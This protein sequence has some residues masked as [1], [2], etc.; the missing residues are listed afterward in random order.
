MLENDRINNL[1]KKAK[2]A[3]QIQMVLSD[4]DKKRILKNRAKTAA[5]E[6]E[7]DEEY[8]QQLEV[9]E[10][11]LDDEKYAIESNYINEVW[12]PKE[13]TSIPCTPTFILGIVNVRGSLVTVIDFKNFFGLGNRVFTENR[14]IIIIQREDIV[15]GLLA[16]SISGIIKI[17]DYEMQPNLS[18]FKSEEAKFIKGI[19]NGG[20]IILDA[21]TLLSDKNLIIHEEADF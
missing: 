11:N 2:E 12:S 21:E 16:D 1:L 14:K 15:A 5:K 8:N 17:Y 4:D 19:T 9:L 18:T 13:I 20:L 10:F 7:R 3:L 6:P